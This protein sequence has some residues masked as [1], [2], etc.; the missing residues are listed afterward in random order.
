M[1]YGLNSLIF[2]GKKLSK[3]I[4][5]NLK[6]ILYKTIKSMLFMCT[7]VLIYRAST[8]LFSKLLGTTNIWVGIMQC[9]LCSLGSLWE[10]GKRSLTLALFMYPKGLESM[11]DLLNQKGWINEIPFSLS[12]L[13]SLSMALAYYLKQIGLINE[14][15]DFFLEKLC[16]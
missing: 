5:G 11:F 13:F 16:S 4:I 1:F 3:D 9:Y 12:F 6:K 8:C 14:N 2:N 10:D 7:G 15:Y